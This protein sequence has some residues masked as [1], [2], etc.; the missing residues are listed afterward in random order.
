MD[1]SADKAPGVP[2]GMKVDE[3][4]NL[5]ST[6]PAACTASGS[7]CRVSGRSGDR[8]QRKFATLRAAPVSSTMC[9]PVPARSAP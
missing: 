4:G 6:G 3:R 7:T 8:T 5:Y 1:M 9:R 2:D